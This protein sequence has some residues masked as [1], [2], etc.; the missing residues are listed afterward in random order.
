MKHCATCTCRDEK[1]A[2]TA[3]C[4][5]TERAYATAWGAHHGKEVPAVTAARTRL[6]DAQMSCPADHS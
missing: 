4:I 3:R 6:Q 1:A 2:H 5:A